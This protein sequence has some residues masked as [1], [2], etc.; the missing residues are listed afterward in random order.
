MKTFLL[1]LRWTNVLWIFI[2][3]LSYLSPFVNPDFFWGFSFLGLAYPWFLLGNFLF[4]IIWVFLK[5]RYFLFS[6]G[7][8]LVGWTHVIN[9]IGFSNTGNLKE[10]DLKVMTYN[11]N[12]FKTL[13]RGNE[14]EKKIFKK[15]LKTFFHSVNADIIC[16]QEAP[17]STTNELKKLI[18]YPYFHKFPGKGTSIFS[19]IPFQKSGTI[20]FE[21][22]NNS[23][24]WIDVQIKKKNIRLYNVHFQSNQISDTA[25]KL[26]SE[27]NLQEKETW[28]GIGGMMRKYRQ[29][30]KARSQQA[31]LVLAH[32]AQSPHPIILCGDFNETPL[33]YIYRQMSQNLKDTFKEKGSGF[34]T[35]YGGNIPALRIDYILVE[36]S[37]E[38]I[39]H[40]I[41][42][43]QFSDHYGVVGRLMLEN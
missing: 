32:I 3:F 16:L 41:L 4:I 28:R 40:Q 29:S 19:K 1:S 34:G 36:P 39:D 11:V 14:T 5:K 7:C 22:S 8:I 24:A 43:E 30:S 27:G 23:S 2:T 12:N 18:P 37:I 25:N 26:A 10:Q 13:I 9:F 6:L 35:T 33:S 20:E 38:V 42:K 21:N 31:K 17:N 15:E